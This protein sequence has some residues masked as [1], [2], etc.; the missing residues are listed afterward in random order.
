MTVCT[1]NVDCKQTQKK[2]RYLCGVSRKKLGCTMYDF[3]VN[4]DNE[5]VSGAVI[6]DKNQILL[7]SK[8]NARRRVFTL[9][10]EIGHIVLGHRDGGDRMVD[11]RSDLI[12]P[13]KRTKEYEANEFAGK[14]LMPEWEFRKKWNEKRKLSIT[15]RI[16]CMTETFGVSFSAATVRAEV[17][18]LYH[19]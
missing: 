9:A 3:A 1:K 18:G 4:E 13:L 2:F 11:T 10:H 14:L 5:H 6:Y 16:S 12:L 15:D 19:A 7:N 8:D 17:L